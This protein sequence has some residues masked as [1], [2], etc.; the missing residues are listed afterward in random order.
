MNII[1]IHAHIFPEEVAKKAI[2]RLSATS[3]I[4]PAH[5]G[6]LNGLLRSMRTAGIT[7]SALMPV[8]TKPEQVAKINQWIAS[9]DRRWFIPFGTLYPLDVESVEAHI[10]QVIALG[11]PGIK[12][13]PNYQNFF[14][15]DEGIFKVY[16]LLE[17]Y[18]LILMLHCGKDLSFDEVKSTPLRVRRVIDSFPRLRVIAAHFGGFKLWDEVEEHLIGRSIYLDTSFTLLF[19]D[20][21]RF[22]RLARKHRIERILFGTDSP[23]TDQKKEVER[24]KQ[25][26]FDSDELENIFYFNSMRL[27]TRAQ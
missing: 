17:R 10:N 11:I 23:W 13:H 25:C 24:I 1:D 9:M 26:G 15:D 4:V 27:I 16:E 5:N 22:V 18:G 6:T 3:G 7:Q 2:P 12:L 21:A 19:M 14:P 20:P 8:A